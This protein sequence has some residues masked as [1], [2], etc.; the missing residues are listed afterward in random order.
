MGNA[1]IP[2]K[3]LLD[4]LQ[5]D[6]V[7]PPFCTKKTLETGIKISPEQ[8][9]LPLKVNLGNYI[10]SAEHGAD[11]VL[12]TGSCGP[13]RFGF[14]GVVQKEILHD[15][16]YN[17]NFII[18]DPPDGHL[19]LFLQRIKRVAGGKSWPYILKCLQKSIRISNICDKLE[20]KVFYIRPREKNYGDTDRL[21]FQYRNDVVSAKG[22][23]AIENVITYYLNELDRIKID[24]NKKPMKIGIIG[25]IYTIIEPFV[26]LNVEQ[27]LGNL[28]I[29]V[30]RSIMVSGWVKNNLVYKAFGS[31]SEK[32]V[33]RA[34]VPYLDRCIGGH[35]WE[36]IGNAVL[37]HSKKYDGV[38]Q[39][40]PFG[41]MPEI[42]AES[43]LP[44]VSRDL[45]YPI[46]TLIVDELT[47]EAG[48]ST[49]LEAFVDLLKYRKK[50]G[51]IH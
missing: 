15:N 43:I 37:Y 36:C 50:E 1:Y 12:I 10:E 41:C 25:E 28:G 2:I 14:Y 47:G 29:E 34:A 33:Y 35:A 27:K 11:T 48:Y 13:C 4:D 8:A 19:D 40:L 42:V 20:K 38:I 6:V 18:L 7:V 32:E 17:M 21:Y 39:I 9:C 51:L 5:M 31:T 49:R 22:S 26:N 44:V 23:K 16:G 46:M 30:D 3:S 45:E 24:M